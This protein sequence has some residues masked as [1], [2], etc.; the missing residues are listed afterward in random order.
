MAAL[1]LDQRE[2]AIATGMSLLSATGLYRLAA[3]R[4]RG[5]GAILMFHRV[6]PLGGERVAPNR[7]LE[8]TPEFLDTVL[9]LLA[10]RGYDLV[11]LDDAL[12]RIAAAASGR[13]GAPFAA[14]TFD[15]A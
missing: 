4:T 14:L 5:I 12:E 6:R 10:R 2:W 13:R 11:S 9:R 15:D 7:G 8:I 3:P 1:L